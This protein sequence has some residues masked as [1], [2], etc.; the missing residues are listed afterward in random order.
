MGSMMTRW[1][2]LLHHS[3]KVLSSTP[4]FSCGLSVWG[5]RAIPTHFDFVPLFKEMQSVGWVSFWFL[6]IGV[7]VCGNGYLCLYVST[8]SDWQPVQGAPISVPTSYPYV[9]GIGFSQPVTLN[10]INGREWMDEWKQC[11][12][13]ITQVPVVGFEPWRDK[14]KRVCSMRWYVFVFLGNF[15]W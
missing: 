6:P 2:A 1:L 3:K 5:L 15:W 10:W 9:A 12:K 11:N 7:N 14:N 13:I 8:G 4:P